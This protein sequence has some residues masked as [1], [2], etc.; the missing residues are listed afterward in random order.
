MTFPP[1]CV[2]PQATLTPTLPVKH[3]LTHTLWQRSDGAAP[4]KLLF[5]NRRWSGG[6]GRWWSV[7]LPCRTVTS[8]SGRS[9]VPHHLPRCSSEPLCLLSSSSNADENT[10]F[11]RRR[12]VKSAHGTS[13]LR[14]NLNFLLLRRHVTARAEIH[15]KPTHLT[16]V[17]TCNEWVR[18][19]RKTDWWLPAATHQGY[20]KVR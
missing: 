18:K 1:S 14:H 5:N 20:N 19:T 8:E 11:A 4:R 3:T 12:L 16:D 10:R 7:T 2:S 15:F 17:T 6:A 13:G 9:A